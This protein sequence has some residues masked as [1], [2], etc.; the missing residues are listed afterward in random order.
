MRA[1][2][3]SS[4][5]SR[6][7]YHV[8]ALRYMYL[9]CAVKHQIICGTSIGAILGSYI[10]Q[11]PYGQESFAVERLSDLFATLKNEDV[12]TRWRP[13]GL[14]SSLFSKP[15]FYNS[16]PLRTFIKTHIDPLRI[17]DTGRALRIG[18]THI[19]PKA[20]GATGVTN[21]C[22]YNENHPDLSKAIMASAAFAPF[23]EPIELGGSMAIDG[24]TQTVTPIKSAIDA[25]ATVIDVIVCYPTYLTYPRSKNITAVDMGLH[26][27]DL[28]LNRLTW[29]DIERTLFINSLVKKGHLQG[30]RA[31]ELNIIHPDVDLEVSSLNFLPK[32]A[33]RLQKKG[34]D[35]AKLVLK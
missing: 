29:I 20:Y 35:D 21:Y 32:D 9:E 34:W 28:M 33:L 5:G 6:G 27:I 10:A 30:A 25:G 22:V 24:G 31:V 13:W 26:V 3:L 16:A 23:F 17:R 4:G 11:Y 14:L 7:Q 2:V 19:Q 1:L 8:G 12:Y 18:A 15:S